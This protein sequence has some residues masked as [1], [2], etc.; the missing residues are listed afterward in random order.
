[1]QTQ[2]L[3]YYAMDKDKN[4]FQ[5]EWKSDN[6]FSILKNGTYTNADINDY[7]ILDM[8]YSI[9][10]DYTEPEWEYL[11]DV[12]VGMNEVESYLYFNK[13]LR[14]FK[15]SAMVGQ[16]V[17]IY[18]MTKSLEEIESDPISRT[19][20]LGYCLSSFSDRDEVTLKD[21]FLHGQF[22]T[23]PYILK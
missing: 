1:M 13:T 10:N 22:I 2:H 12:L 15:T 7:E 8:A 5:F 6:G 18:K 21:V 20:I 14:Q 4:L 16:D 19:M 17:R 3:G 9:S 23:Q 11:G